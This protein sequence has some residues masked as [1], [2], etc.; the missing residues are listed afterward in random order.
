MVGP[1]MLSAHRAPNSWL[2]GYNEPLLYISGG[3]RNTVDSRLMLMKEDTTSY[4]IYMFM[5]QAVSAAAA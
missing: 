4:H 5:K 3:L 1:N 2:H